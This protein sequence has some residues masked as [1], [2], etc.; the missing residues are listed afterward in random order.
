LSFLPDRRFL[1]IETLFLLVIMNLV[2][3]PLTEPD[4]GWH[5]RSGLD[6]IAHGGHLPL[7]DPYSH[8]MP[9]WPW[10]EHAWL[11]DLLIGWVYGQI[12]SYG[13]LAV[14]ILFGLITAGAWW[15]AGLTARASGIIRL[16]AC[17]LSL[18]VALPFLGARTQLIT[19]LGMA[20][21]LWMLQRIRNGAGL[22]IW[23]FPAIFLLWSNLHGGFTAGLFL[24]VLVV[25][26]SWLMPM[27]TRFWPALHERSDEPPVAPD[28]RRQLVAATG[29]S[30]LVTLVNPYGWRLHQEI[31]ESLS[32]RFM[33]DTLQEW[34]SPSF[35]TVAGKLFFS[36]L[37]VLAL[38][39]VCWYRRIEPLRWTVLAV[40]LALACRHFRNIPLFLIVSLPLLAELMQTAVDRISR[41]E[42]VRRIS[43]LRWVGG[44]TCLLAGL[45]LYLGPDHAERVWGAGVDPSGYFRGTSYPIEAVGWIHE[46]RD[47]VGTRLYNEY[48][49]GGFLLWWLPEEKIFIDG[50]MPAWHIGDR[51]ILRDYVRLNNGDP[52]ELGILDRYGVDWALITKGAPLAQALGALPAWH[53]EYEDEKVCIFRKR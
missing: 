32:D 29:L 27:F 30:A 14:I 22:K 23:Q 46:H 13:A 35:E 24:L 4:F 10:V 33:I 20:V 44:L 5:L 38:A 53:M 21:L 9:D 15:V 12:G 1:A 6:F 52:A 45:V 7:L 34:Q 8:T 18:W 39:A 48:G 2:L 43:S 31:L 47:H 51:H 42:S 11:T 28:A 50:R 16:C 25:G 3:Q 26:S 19:V 40:F 37:F 49:H 17:S 36:Y 41:V